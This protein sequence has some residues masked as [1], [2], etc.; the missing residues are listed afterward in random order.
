MKC[1]LVL[2][3]LLLSPSTWKADTKGP[4]IKTRGESIILY[5]RPQN[6][7]DYNSPDS[8]TIQKIIKEQEWVI[9]YINS[10]IATNF[11]SKVRIY[12]YNL[13]EAKAKIGTSGGGF[14]SLGKIQPKIYFAFRDQPIFDPIRK[15]NVYVGIHEMVHVVT[16]NQLGPIRSAFFGEGY[17]NA[18]DGCYGSRVL[19][20]HL[21]FRRNDSTV[22]KIKEQGRLL[23]PHDLLYDS[24]IPAGDFYPQIG[25]LVGWMFDTYG[26]ESMNRLY[27]LN[28]Y[29]IEDEFPK[30][31][32]DSFDEMATKYLTYQQN[33]Q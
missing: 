22:M 31:T 2:L 26:V 28:R 6:Y 11:K 30:V 32:G 21:V 24:H 19:D 29:K 23:S 27:S 1:S 25:C 13:D 17:A 15:K 4:W 5:T 7:S 9:D 20:D 12:L 16:R 8:L 18:I 3:I 14:A 10:S 33:L